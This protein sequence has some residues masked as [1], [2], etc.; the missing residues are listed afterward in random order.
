MVLEAQLHE[1]NCFITLTYNDDK[2]PDL[3]SL[4]RK[5]LTSFWKKL[6][7]ARGPFRYY[8]CG[9]YGDNTKRAHYHACLFGIE[10]PDKVELQRKQD[11]VLYYS[12][13]LTDIWG[14]GH[15]SI[16][17]L[18]FETAAYCARYVIKKMKGEGQGTFALQE[19]TGELIPV[20]QP[21]AVMSLRPAIGRNWLEKF[22]GDIYQADKDFLA[23]RGKEMKPAKYFDR[24]MDNIDPERIERIKKKRKEE[25]EPKTLNELRTHEKITR[26]RIITKSQI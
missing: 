6:R 26:A 20:Q 9:E 1:S 18:T 14:Q 16:G 25:R 2:L 13:Q 10:F 17:A 21:Y 12:Q 3:G 7:K 22:N 23:M 15:T 8:A 11:T 24:L 19:E 4:R 5:D